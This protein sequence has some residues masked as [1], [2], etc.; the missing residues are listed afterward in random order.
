LIIVM[1]AVLSGMKTLDDLVDYGELKAE[2]LERI[3]AIHKIPSRTTFARI[4][5]ILDPE[6]VGQA[7]LTFVKNK[8]GNPGNQI[9]FD[10][11]AIRATHKKGHEQPLHILSAMAT[12]T[13]I[14]LASMNVPEKTNEIP[15]IREM[16]ELLN[17]EGKT[18][19]AD[20]LNTQKETVARIV[21]KKGDYVLPVKENHKT[22]Y[23]DIRFYL[24]DLI[25]KHEAQGL[26]YASTT[27]GTKAKTVLRECWVLSDFE[28]FGESEQ[29]VGLRSLIALRR[30]TIKHGIETVGEWNFFISN[31]HSEPLEFLS[32]I[33]SHWSIESM[34]WW[35]DVILGEDASRF[36]ST[37]AQLTLNTL[38]KLA[39]AVHKDFKLKT[40]SKKSLKSS[41]TRT[42]LDDTRLMDLITL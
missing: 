3:F 30:T 36:G 16:I 17:I 28:T 7:I 26:D 20:A 21:E 19:T 34:H 22:F 42:L 13:G 6:L 10:G 15:M 32:I 40:N 23:H 33:R 24:L 9:A 14:T 4:L 11:K 35:G 29:W 1:C 25:L 37:A 41:M 31:L 2:T 39:L 12:Q 38:R 5:S 27:E 18:V 8:W